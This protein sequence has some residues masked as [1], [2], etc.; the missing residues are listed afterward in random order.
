MTRGRLLVALLAAFGSAPLSAQTLSTPIFQSPYRDFRQSELAGYVSDPGS[1]V[2]I[3]VQGEYRIARP[4]FD[5]GLMVGY[6][7]GSGTNNSLFGVGIEA[8]AP[9]AGH[10]Q[11]FPFDA[12]L[13]GGFGALFGGGSS[14]FLVPLG[15]SLGRQLLLEN[16]NISFTPY[17]NP[18]IVPTFGKLYGDVQFALGLGVDISLSRTFDAR[19]SG[20]LGDISGVGVGLAWH[21]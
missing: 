7:D 8:R 2:S 6:L 12:T 9:V 4:K 21:R 20:S 11:Q 1:G 10:S 17:L 16:S 13:T 15:V 18:V 5:F 14:G 19:V 3:A